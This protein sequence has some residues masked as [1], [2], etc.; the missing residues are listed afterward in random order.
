MLFTNETLNASKVIYYKRDDCDIYVVEKE[1]KTYLIGVFK[2][3]YSTYAKVTI[4]FAS[5]WSCENIL[6]SPFGYFVFS[7]NEKELLEK[8]KRK[9][10]ELRINVLG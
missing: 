9:I 1:D 2:G 4:A 5:S 3:Q 8:I 10:E 6:Y 7:D